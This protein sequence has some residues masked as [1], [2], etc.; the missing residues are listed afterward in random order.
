VKPVFIGDTLR[1]RVTLK[2]KRDSSNRPGYGTV[3][4]LLEA[5]DQR[6]EAVLECE[7]LLLVKRKG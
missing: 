3:V 7:H 5:F 6:H 4:E 1:L 2:E